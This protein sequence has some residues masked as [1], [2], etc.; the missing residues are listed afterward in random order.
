MQ[1]SLW[2]AKSPTKVRMSKRI[3]II[4]GGP[5]GYV[6]AIRFAQLGAQVTLFEKDRIGGTCLNRGCIPTKALHRSAE[7]YHDALHSESFGIDIE[8][9]I[10]PNG[11]KIYERKAKV[12]ETLVTGVEQLVSANG[13]RVIPM[14]AR[15]KNDRVV[16]WEEGEERFDAIIL[17]TG[18]A[19]TVPPIEGADLPGLLDSDQLLAMAKIPESMLVLGGSVVAMEF[20]SIYAT[21]GTKV[22][23]AVRSQILR[24][25]DGEIV[26]R[27]K[28]LY[29][30]QGIEINEKA[31]PQK[32]EKIDGGFRVTFDKAGKEMTVEAEQVLLALGRGPVTEGLGL[33]E[34][35]VN[36]H[37]GYV[38]VDENLKTSAEGIYAIGDVN[39]IALLAH[40]AE[41]QGV[42]VAEYIMKGTPVEHVPVPNCIFTLPEIAT[43]G[44]SEEELKAQGVEYKTSKFMMAANGKALALGE[45]DGLI[46]VITNMDNQLIGVHIF[47]AHAS[48]IIHE[49]ILAV[50]KGMTVEDIKSVMHA[51]PTL[52]EAF[53]EAVLGIEG[54]AIHAVPKKRR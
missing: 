27:I 11:D 44:Y 24:M 37:R 52:P 25:V 47:G 28:P 12:V 38:T 1:R 51:H 34:A 54:I 48:D 21:L 31:T 45:T 32:I 17:A 20:A 41:H 43:I 2:F 39:G 49:A 22:T 26:K 18:T 50:T 3:A 35:G 42:A 7:V 23:Q 6:S 29:K 15:L 53:F 13:I 33:E 10:R 14:E 9:S 19:P 8:G 46:K 30:K 40:A 4:G 36:L 16:A 5:G